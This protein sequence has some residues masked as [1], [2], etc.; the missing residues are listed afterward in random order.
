[1]AGM[2][3][4]ETDECNFLTNRSVFC[5]TK[6]ESHTHLAFHIQ[7][8]AVLNKGLVSSLQAIEI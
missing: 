8:P 7:S 1:M 3:V 6:K 4:E 2:Y 5:S